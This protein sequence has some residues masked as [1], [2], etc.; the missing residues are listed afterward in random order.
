MNAFFRD[1]RLLPIVLLATVIFFCALGI[2][3]LHALSL[4]RA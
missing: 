4:R 3:Q 1:L 2:K